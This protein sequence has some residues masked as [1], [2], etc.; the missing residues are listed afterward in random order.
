MKAA[1][2]IL[3][4][5][6]MLGQMFRGDF[7]ILDYYT[8]Q[9]RYAA[10]CVN[11]EKPQMHCNGRCQMDKKL[12]QAHQEASHNPETAGSAKVVLTLY[13]V[14]E[15]LHFDWVSLPV[16]KVHYYA[17]EDYPIRRDLL[18]VFHPPEWYA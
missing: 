5:I 7:I 13:C 18:P 15:N 16:Q 3:L 8:H 10:L 4:F 14:V 2:A 11:K 6:A 17:K 12:Q 9:Q 1:V